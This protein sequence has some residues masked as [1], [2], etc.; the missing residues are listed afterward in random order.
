MERKNTC[1]GQGEKFNSKTNASFVRNHI[2]YSDSWKNCQ[3]F[4]ITKKRLKVKVFVHLSKSI[5]PTVVTSL[6]NFFL[7]YLNHVY[8]ETVYVRRVDLT[9]KLMEMLEVL[10][11]QQ[12]KEIFQEELC[13]LLKREITKEV[14]R[15]MVAIREEEEHQ[16]VKCCFSCPRRVAAKHPQEGNVKSDICM[17][18]ASTMFALRRQNHTKQDSKGEIQQDSLLYC[19]GNP[20]LMKSRKTIK[21]R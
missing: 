21:Y 11:F 13:V 8:L 16:S 9:T 2:L 20:T 14:R 5:L 18:V 15:M 7:L 3:L 17:C 6:F 19:H 1:F 10:G 4:H 12:E